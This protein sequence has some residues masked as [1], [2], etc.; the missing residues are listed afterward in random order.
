M[1]LSKKLPQN[2]I[3]GL[4][5]N[6]VLQLKLWLVSVN[7]ITYLLYSITGI[8]I[9]LLL[10]LHVILL[11]HYNVNKILIWNLLQLISNS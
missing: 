6:R 11:E 8:C 9:H 4:K 3:H 2:G 10:K 7:I 5:L 1:E